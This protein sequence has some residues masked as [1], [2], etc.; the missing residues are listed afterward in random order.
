MK[1]TELFRRALKGANA[2]RHG[3]LLTMDALDFMEA[4]R[5]EIADIVFVDPP[6]NLGKDYGIQCDLETCDDFVYELYLSDLLNEA[7]RVLRPGGALFLYHMPVW[8]VRLGAVLRDSLQFRHWIAISMKNG[9]ARGRRLYPAHYALLY[10]TKGEPQKFTRPKIDPQTCRHCGKYVK[11]Y[12]GYLEI[13]E[14]KGVNLSDFWDDLS[15]VRHSRDKH[16]QANQLPVLLTDRVVHI[17]GRNNGLLIDPFAG[18][19]TSLVSAA[20][21]GMRVAG[22]DLSPRNVRICLSRLSALDI[23]PAK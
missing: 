18:T 17:A 13:I 2:G 16:R 8:A 21:I 12:G 11:D 5:D 23:Q 14:N 6:F 4:L 20:S 22:N 9:F 10:L 7:V 1:K 15:P 19:G 3:V